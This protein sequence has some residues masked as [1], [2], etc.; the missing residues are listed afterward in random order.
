MAK[1]LRV[2]MVAGLSFVT[3]MGYGQ[4]PAAVAASAPALLLKC[5]SA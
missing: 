1:L 3:V 5:D 4:A 2:L